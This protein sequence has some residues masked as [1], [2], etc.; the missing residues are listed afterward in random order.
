ML[1]IYCEKCREL[2]GIRC[3]HSDNTHKD[4]S[5]NIVPVEDIKEVLKVEIERM[6]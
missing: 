5:H 3:A 6:R 1:N 2:L 4:K